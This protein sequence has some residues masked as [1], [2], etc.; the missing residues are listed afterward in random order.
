MTPGPV[1]VAVI[2]YYGPGERMSDL[3]DLG[4]LA[5]V[6]L[7]CLVECGVFQNDSPR[8]IKP[9][10]ADCQRDRTWPRLTVLWGQDV[11]RRYGL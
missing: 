3:S 4:F 5:K 11:K 2:A 8:F 10:I 1:P 6:P 9:F 7:D